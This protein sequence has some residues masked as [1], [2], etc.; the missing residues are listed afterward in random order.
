MDSVIFWILHGI[1]TDKNVL[2]TYLLASTY[3]LS[4]IATESPAEE[5]SVK[6]A[7]WGFH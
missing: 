2:S 6:S 5:F 4:L 7:V 1:T 3:L